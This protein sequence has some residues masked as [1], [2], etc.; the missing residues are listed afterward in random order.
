MHNEK[1]VKSVIEK[2]ENLLNDTFV[3]KQFLKLEI[4]KQEIEKFLGVTL[5]NLKKDSL[6]NN[7]PMFNDNG[8]YLGNSFDYRFSML[9]CDIVILIETKNYITNKY[10]DGKD[11]RISN[12]KLRILK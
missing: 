12:I 5:M 6:I 11:E 3:E 8:H 4:T 10:E 2:I 9:E 1:I 7:A